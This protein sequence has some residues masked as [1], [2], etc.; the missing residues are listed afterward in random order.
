MNGRNCTGNI[1][2][3]DVYCVSY[4]EK[5]YIFIDINECEAALSPCQHSCENT[6]GSFTCSCSDGFILSDDQRSCVG[7]LV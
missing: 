6:V 7:M 2:T 4:V 1:I 5:L 3:M